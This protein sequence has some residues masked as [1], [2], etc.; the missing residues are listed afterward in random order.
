MEHDIEENRGSFRQ[1]GSEK[2]TRC[3]GA[4]DGRNPSALHHPRKNDLKNSNGKP[5]HR[6]VA[7]KDKHWNNE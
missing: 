2:K 4:A 7:G 5:F 3:G 6:R 1:N